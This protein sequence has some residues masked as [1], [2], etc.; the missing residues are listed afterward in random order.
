VTVDDGEDDGEGQGSLGPSE[1]DF[2]RARQVGLASSG[3]PGLK[4]GLASSWARVVG[5]GAVVLVARCSL[6]AAGC[7]V[8]G[9]VCGP[10]AGPAGGHCLD[11]QRR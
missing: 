9:T 7:T 1:R 10:A 8:R 5:N 3:N 11:G 6:L 2:E 4:P